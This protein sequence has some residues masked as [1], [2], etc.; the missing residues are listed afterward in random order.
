M[1]FCFFGNIAI[2]ADHMMFEHGC[3]RVAIFDFDVHHGNGTQHL[4]EERDDIFFASVH[5]APFYPGT[6][7]A[8]ERGVGAGEGATLNVP[9]PAGTD[10]ALF[11][12]AVERQRII[13]KVLAEAHGDVSESDDPDEEEE[14]GSE[15][16]DD[17]SPVHAWLIEQ[18]RLG[19]DPFEIH[20]GDCCQH[21]LEALE[22]SR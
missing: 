19:H 16:D 14:E 6:G 22:G 1:G 21:G 9:L 15:E 7:D 4:L 5:Q 17:A 2:A 8:S 11:Q 3:S 20:P 13:Q 18:V 12:A 10:D